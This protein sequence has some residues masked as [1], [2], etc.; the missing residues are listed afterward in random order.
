MSR[1]LTACLYGLNL[2]LD[3]PPD[4][5]TLRLTFT[6]G[7]LQ[8]FALQR[9]AHLVFLDRSP[10]IFYAILAWGVGVVAWI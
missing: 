7:I 10:P 8:A 6:F 1:E 2:V 4:D 9:F 5:T 3:A